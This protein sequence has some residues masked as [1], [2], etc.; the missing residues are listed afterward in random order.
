LLFPQPFSKLHLRYIIYLH[1]LQKLFVLAI[2]VF[3]V[4]FYLF[5]EVLS[6]QFLNFAFSFIH[7]LLELLNFLIAFLK[8]FCGVFRLL[9]YLVEFGIYFLFLIA[10][11]LFAIIC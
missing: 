1:G 5:F 7:V 8:N 6:D 2:A 3:F 4:E 10:N 11:L 9:L